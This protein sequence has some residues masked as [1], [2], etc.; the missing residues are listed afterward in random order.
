MLMDLQ[1]QGIRNLQQERDCHFFSTIFSSP[2]SSTG[3]KEA[4]GYKS[5]AFWLLQGVS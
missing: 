4:Q 2:G 5:I 3:E 1:L